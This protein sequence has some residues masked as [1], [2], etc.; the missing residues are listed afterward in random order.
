MTM[1][2][3]KTI[4]NRP[5]GMVNAGNN[6]LNYDHQSKDVIPLINNIQRD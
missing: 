2:S 5:L 4:Y 6:V 1:R 3:G